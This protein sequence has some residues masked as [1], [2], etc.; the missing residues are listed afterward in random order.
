[1]LLLTHSLNLLFELSH[2]ILSFDHSILS[3]TSHAVGLDLVVLSVLN[4]LDI[5]EFDFLV[6]LMSWVT[7]EA[8]WFSKEH[9]WNQNHNNNEES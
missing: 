3:A 7:S 2:L 6:F 8:A 4:V 1:M 9:D 5:S